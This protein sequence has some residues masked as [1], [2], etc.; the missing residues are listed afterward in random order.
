MAFGSREAS[1]VAC[2]WEDSWIFMLDDTLDS[3][4]SASICGNMHLHFLRLDLRYEKAF[5]SS[6]LSISDDPLSMI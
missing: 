3:P 6:S 2:I 5:P 1:H 4:N